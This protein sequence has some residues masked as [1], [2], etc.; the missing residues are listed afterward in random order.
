VSQTDLEVCLIF[1]IVIGGV[2]AGFIWWDRRK[3]KRSAEFRAAAERLGLEFAPKVQATFLSSWQSFQIFSQGHGKELTN[4]IHGSRDGVDVALFD[5]EFTVGGLGHGYTYCQ[6]VCTI[7]DQG[8]S[9]PSFEMQ[10]MDLWIRLKTI[11]GLRHVVIETCPEL[12]GEY[13]LRGSPEDQVRALFR[14]PVAEHFRGIKR[15][16]VEGCGNQLVYYR[17]DRRISP[18]EVEA[19]LKEALCLLVLFRGG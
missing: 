11:L 9:L 3:R 16:S 14:L 13:L 4:V 19:L 15:A 6:T 7:R 10:P 12:S 8:L 17:V 5:F 2:I 18:G 1:L